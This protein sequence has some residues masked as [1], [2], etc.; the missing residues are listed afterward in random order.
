VLYL[1]YG[2]PN[3][4]SGGFF[5]AGVNGTLNTSAAAAATSDGATITASPN[6][7]H[8]VAGADGATT[9]TWNAPSAQ[10]IQVRVNS[11]NGALFTDNFNT[12]SMMTGAW[13]TNG[14]MLFLQDVTNGKALTAANTLATVVIG[15][16]T[17]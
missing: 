15:V 2:A 8:V 4:T 13:V 14:T 7:I 6:P 12:G 9:V 1:A 5:P 11:P 17:P 16:V 3:A 10:I